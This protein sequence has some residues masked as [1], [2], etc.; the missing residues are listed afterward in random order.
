M[1]AYQNRGYN[2]PKTNSPKFST[3][4]G[5][6]LP[7]IIDQFYAE[8]VVPDFLPADLGE[9]NPDEIDFDTGHWTVDPDGDIRTDPMSRREARLMAGIPDEDSIIVPPPVVSNDPTPQE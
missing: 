6:T 3:T 4:P 7:A 1:R 9:D 2:K 5:F 8:G